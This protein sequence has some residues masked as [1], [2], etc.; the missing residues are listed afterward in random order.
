MEDGG[1]FGGGGIEV[2]SLEVVEHVDI[3]AGVGRVLN[4]NDVGLGQLGAGA[5]AVDV[6]AD[7]G[8]GSDFGELVEY[9]DFANVTAMEDAID[10]GER[11][12]D[13]GTKEA[14]GVGDD[15]EFHVFRISC[16]G[17]GRLREGAPQSRWTKYPGS[18]TI[19]L[20]QTGSA[21]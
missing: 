9:G 21:R 13:F 10:A 16:A 14:V 12:S 1:E 3:E 17:G 4:E 2:E 6:A 11:G 15:S 7:R 8:D 5:F 20:E 18:N 19:T